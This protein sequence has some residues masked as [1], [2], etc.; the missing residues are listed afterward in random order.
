MFDNN[1]EEPEVNEELGYAIVDWHDF[2][3]DTRLIVHDHVFGGMERQAGRHYEPI[4]DVSKPKVHGQPPEVS[5][6]LQRDLDRIFP[7]SRLEETIKRILPSKEI[8]GELRWFV[9]KK[10]YIKLQTILNEQYFGRILND[11][12]D[13]GLMDMCCDKG[14]IVYRLTPKGK[15]TK[16]L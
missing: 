11:M 3:V 5:E 10:N 13:Q 6:T 14:E 1:D 12:V 7:L 9:N 8:Q 2:M 16:V 15:N 4:I